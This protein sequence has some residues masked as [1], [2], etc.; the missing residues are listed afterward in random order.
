MVNGDCIHFENIEK[1]CKE[2]AELKYEAI[3]KPCCVLLA[4]IECIKPYAEKVCAQYSSLDKWAKEKLNRR[5]EEKESVCPQFTDC[6]EEAIN[7]WIIIIT[8]FTA[9]IAICAF[10]ILFVNNFI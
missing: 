9:L 7:I 4:E 5:I 3:K 10:C 1:F 2:E 8:L 6:L